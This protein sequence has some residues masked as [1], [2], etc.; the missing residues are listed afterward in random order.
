MTHWRLRLPMMG[1]WVLTGFLL[2]APTAF[3]QKKAD[4]KKPAPKS[5]LKPQAATPANTLKVAKGFHAELL[6]SVPKDVEGSWVSMCTD[7]QGRLIVCDQYGGL[8][9]VTPPPLG[10]STGM[11]LE[12][13]PAAIGDAQGLLWAFDSL[14]VMVNSGRIP[15]GLYRVTDSNGDDQLD[16]VELLRKIAGG[17]AEHGPHAILLHPDGKRLTVVCGNQCQLVDAQSSLVPRFW[18]EDHLLPRLP[19]GNGFMKGVLAP[20]G[21]IYNVTPD[22]KEWELISVGFRNEYDAA[23]NQAGQLFAYDADMEWDA[24]TPWYRPTRVCHVVPG[25]DWGWRNGAG[26][27]PV[28]YPDTLPP[29]VNIGP[30]SPTGVTFGYG[31][32][33]PEKY[34]NALYICDWSYGKLYA[35]HLKP[36]GTTY[37]GE[38]EEFIAGSP[39]PLTD[40]VVN[41]KD[42]ALYFAIGGRKTQSGLYRVTYTGPE[43]T[44]PI[45]TAA[46]HTQ[47]R[48]NSSIDQS[49]TNLTNPDRF[50]RYTARV[51]LEAQPVSTWREKA[52]AETRPEASALALLA[53]TR[54]SAADPQHAR[55]NSP[56]ADPALRGQ[57]LQSLARHDLRKLDDAV[58]C[59]LLRVYEVLFNRFG[60]PTDAER[61]AVL[62]K[63][64]S[65][66]PSGHRFVDSMLLEVLVYLQSPKAVTAV[67]LL[68]EAPTQEEQLDYAK[69]LRMLQAG[70]TPETRKQ[71]FE[72]FTR[73]GG[74]KGGNSFRGFLTMIKN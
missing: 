37:T 52:L 26:K 9:R 50:V 32:K 48:S 73:A 40:I 69:S 35:V 68:L 55:P 8:Y 72:W 65:A 49:W 2:T 16:K 46:P 59:D 14:Y 43:K 17:G 23:Y 19:D 71:Y 44:T 15:S 41:P 67:K 11:K 24:N 53:L 66:F 12:K 18:G 57:I 51:H 47:K 5:A 34:Q 31:A 58:V 42:G 30:G 6:Y 54:V 20:G 33:F 38:A 56:K 39:L 1:L 13:V 36:D 22:G 61:S 64:E 63:L 29:V 3:A 4:P 74:Y 60:P 45:A 25:S 10:T 70:W 62:A 28:Y 7:P 27:Y 21:C